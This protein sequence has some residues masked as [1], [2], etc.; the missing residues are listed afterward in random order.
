VNVVVPPATILAE[1]RPLDTNW[2]AFVPVEA[3]TAIVDTVAELLLVTVKVKGAPTLWH[4]VPKLV[5]VLAVIARVGRVVK[6]LS[7]P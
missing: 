6:L 4:T 2:A 7:V 3:A 1:P 5:L